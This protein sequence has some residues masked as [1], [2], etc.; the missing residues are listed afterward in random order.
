MAKKTVIKKK[1]NVKATAATKKPAAKKMVK[2][3][4]KPVAKKITAKKIAAKPTTK[5]AVKPVAKKAALVKKPI[6]KPVAKKAP[7]KKAATKK[8]APAVSGATVIT[9]ETLAS[10]NLL[11]DF[12]KK[13]EGNWDHN[14]WVELCEELKSKGYD[15]SDFDRV[16]LILEEK[17]VE[18][19]N[20]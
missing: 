8:T 16:G 20:S 7:V 6:A 1:T 18:Y 12:V 4:V 15:P 19:F 11:L 10:S 9:V 2:K 5:K 3:V 17:K 14:A 13:Y